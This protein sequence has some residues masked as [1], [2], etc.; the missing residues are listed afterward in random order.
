MPEA[1]TPQTPAIQIIRPEGEQALPERWSALTEQAREYL[2]HSKAKNTRRA[3]RSD[4]EDFVGWCR[5]HQVESLP[6]T[7][8]TIVLYLTDCAIGLKTSTL[9]RRLA[10]IS[11]AHQTAEFDTP[12]QHPAV[13]AVWQGI[14]RE[15]GVAMQGKEP[16]LTADIRCMIEYLPEGKLIAIRDRCLLLLGFAGAMRRS[17]LVGL[18]V[19]DIADTQAGLVVTIRRSKTDPEGAGR[20]I[21][22]PYG[23]TPLTCPVRAYRDWRAASGI[24]TGPLFRGMNRHGHLISNRLSDQVVAKVVKRALK[25]AGREADRFAGHSLRAGLATQA[26]ENGVPERVI[27]EQ[28]GHKSLL[29]LRRYIRQ[30]SLFQENAA[31]KVGL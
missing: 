11:Q 10:S 4:W 20:Q 6:A 27:Q 2:K 25:A 8:E 23:S 16:A 15:K 13:R 7:P 24:E 29:I 18:D 26:A 28:T 19:E 31:S 12:T 14:K 3:Y 1:P 30:G 21:G 22:I 5:H 17:E 9:Q